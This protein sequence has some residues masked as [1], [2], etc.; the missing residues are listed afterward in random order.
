[1]LLVNNRNGRKGYIVIE[2]VPWISWLPAISLHHIYLVCQFVLQYSYEQ[3]QTHVTWSNNVWHGE[4]VLL[5]GLSPSFH[6]VYLWMVLLFS[7]TVYRILND[8]EGTGVLPV[9]YLD[10]WSVCAVINT[11]YEARHLHTHST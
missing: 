4:V 8:T 3:R 9:T 10:P 1:M 2:T 7:N 5:K 6:H 11:W